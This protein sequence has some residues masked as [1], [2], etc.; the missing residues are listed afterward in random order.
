MNYLYLV[1]FTAIISYNLKAQDGKILNGYDPITDDISEKYEA[2]PYLIYDCQS[3][4]WICVLQSYYENCQTSRDKDL[5]ENLV[6]L[7][8][9]PI[10]E[11]PN[12][13]SCFQRQLFLASQSHGV[14]FCIADSWKKKEQKT[15]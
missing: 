15:Q 13:K 1:L 3:Q 14:R 10:G 7:S 11:F 5:K 8:C 9:A 12:K 4:S 2:G 6:N